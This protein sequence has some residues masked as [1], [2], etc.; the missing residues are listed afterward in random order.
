M[1]R[2]FRKNSYLKQSVWGELK[3]IAGKDAEKTIGQ[4][5]I[6]FK[7]DEND[8]RLAYRH[9]DEKVSDVNDDLDFNLLDWHRWTYRNKDIR[10][11]L[12]PQFP[13]RAV[14]V[15]P[16]SSFKILKGSSIRVYVRIPIWV[17]I[18][19]LGNPKKILLQIP[20][21]ILSN[22]WFGDFLQGEVCYWISSG[23]RLKIE[24]DPTRPYLAICP[25]KLINKSEEDLL[26]EKICLR[27]AYLSLYIFKS[28]L[29]ADEMKLCYKGKDEINE[30]T[31]SGKAPPEAKTGSLVSS[32]QLSIKKSISAKTFSTI[33]D[34]PGL[35]IF[36]K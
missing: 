20:S 29:W 10:I 5:K 22:T 16:E 36:I 14:V 3:D 11:Q 23:V 26:I 8:F 31:V 1:N 30:I 13:D 12:K 9:N 4:L 17:K 28:Q 35:G 24:E 15:K 19:Y 32:P 6:W 7:H 27:V 21:T 34:L 2:G 33:Q 18:E 25:L